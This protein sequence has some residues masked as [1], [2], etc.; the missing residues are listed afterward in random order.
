MP[1]YE[2]KCKK[3]GKVFEVLFRSRNEKLKVCCPGCQSAKTEKIFSVFGSR[4]EKDAPSSP[5]PPC[6][7]NC[8]EFS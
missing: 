3:C 5:V 4:V 1:I 7:A 2:F 6:A 8:T